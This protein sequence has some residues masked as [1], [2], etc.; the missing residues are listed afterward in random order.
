MDEKVIVSAN[1]EADQSEGKAFDASIIKLAVLL[2][3]PLAT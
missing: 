3:F 1:G 2:A